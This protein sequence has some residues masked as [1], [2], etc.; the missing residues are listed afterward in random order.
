MEWVQTED[1][2]GNY[3]AWLEEI[4]KFKTSYVKVGITEGTADHTP[5]YDGQ[6][7]APMAMIAFVH[8]MGAIIKVTEKMRRFLHWI[9]IHLKNSTNE[10]HIPERSFIRSW[11]HEQTAGIQNK[12]I[13]LFDDVNS[14]KKNCKSALDE[15]GR[16]GQEG[17]KNKFISNSWPPLKFRSGEPLMDTKQLYDSISFETVIK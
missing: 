9:G 15:L 3:D 8:E 13:T 16:F 6:P 2:R 11:V 12:I 4:R 7:A 17:I 5:K 1:N 14:R 10:I